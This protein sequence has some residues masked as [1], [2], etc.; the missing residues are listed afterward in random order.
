MQNANK[1]IPILTILLLVGGKRRAFS[2]A[3]DAII[4]TEKENLLYRWKKERPVNPT[5][6]SAVLPSPQARPVRGH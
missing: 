5:V 1:K 4:H 2:G 6:S 3:W